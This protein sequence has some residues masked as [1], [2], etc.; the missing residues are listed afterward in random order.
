M[1]QSIVEIVT[2][3]ERHYASDPTTSDRATL[4][5]AKPLLQQQ[6]QVFPLDSALVHLAETLYFHLGDKQAIVD[7]LSRYLTQ[8]LSVEEQ[9]RARWELVDNL[10]MLRR[11]N[12]AVEAQKAFLAWAH[13]HLPQNRLLWVM[14]DSTQ[15]FC[16]LE[17]GKADEWL[18]VF[19]D[20]MESVQVAPEN[21]YDRFFLLRTAG[22]LLNRK[23]SSRA[24]KPL[25]VAKKMHDLCN[26]DASWDRCVEVQLEAYAIETHAYQLLQD[27]TALRHA[28]LEGTALIQQCRTDY[29]RLNVMCNNLAGP[30]YRAGQYDLSI[31]LHQRAIELGTTSEH[32]YLWLAAALW[33]TTKDRSQVLPILRQGGPRCRGDWYKL[34]GVAEF[35]D[36]VA[37]I[38]FQN[39]VK[40]TTGWRRKRLF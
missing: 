22:E 24:D 40:L 5:A 12:E 26:E 10:A 21:R 38:E 11:C 14:Y 33:A 30:L 18:S 6:L 16:W 28:G 36:V 2:D 13:K 34:E 17:V 7:L 3:F 37:D 20:F 29:P 23:Q 1:G 39:A 27:I 32:A 25:Q 4:E 31:P 15:A 19:N 8:P 35:H 9:A